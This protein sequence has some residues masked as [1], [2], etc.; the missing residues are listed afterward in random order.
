M[1][2]SSP[3]RDGFQRAACRVRQITPVLDSAKLK[4]EM[5][6]RALEKRPRAAKPIFDMEQ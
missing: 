6:M 2:R 5:P 4:V 3:L 1:D